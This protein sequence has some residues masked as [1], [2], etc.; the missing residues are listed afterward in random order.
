MHTTTNSIMC[1]N[2]NISFTIYLFVEWSFPFFLYHPPS[3]VVQNALAIRRGGT[4][5]NI[6]ERLHQV[7]NNHTLRFA[8]QCIHCNTIVRLVHLGPITEISILIEVQVQKITKQWR[9][10]E[11]VCFPTTYYTIVI[12]SFYW[13]LYYILLFFLH[14]K[15]QHNKPTIIT[16][17]SCG[18][19]CSLVSHQSSSEGMR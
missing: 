10:W 6:T 16:N 13:L 11:I 17:G 18:S 12:L 9:R 5:R 7:H 4:P 1:T 8:Y 3:C 2:Y 14:H 15:Q 19:H